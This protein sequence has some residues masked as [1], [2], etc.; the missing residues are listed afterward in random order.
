VSLFWRAQTLLAGG[1]SGVR[2]PRVTQVAFVIASLAQWLRRGEQ[3]SKQKRKNSKVEIGRFA[4]L[5]VSSSRVSTAFPVC[6]RKFLHKL[7]AVLFVPFAILCEG[8]LWMQRGL[9]HFWPSSGSAATPIRFF[10]SEE[11]CAAEKAGKIGFETA[12]G[13]A[14]HMTQKVHV[15][16]DETMSPAQS[17]RLLDCFRN[18]IALLCEKVPVVSVCEDA[19]VFV[20]V[21]DGGMEASKKKKK[22]ARPRIS[23]LIPCRLHC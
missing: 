13:L 16:V 18:E 15:V 6:G 3:Q 4:D 11:V 22:V 23:P 12:K 10:C 2:L 17:N 7:G 9:G 20:G 8:L 5:V 19:A 14:Q 1:I 21:T